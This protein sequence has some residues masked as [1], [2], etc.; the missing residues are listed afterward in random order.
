[1]ADV[2]DFQTT[3]EGRQYENEIMIVLS[4]EKKDYPNYFGGLNV[5]SG[6]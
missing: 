6:H 5:A 2:P 3:E 4:S 1:M